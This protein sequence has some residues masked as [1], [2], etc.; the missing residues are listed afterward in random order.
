LATFED[1]KFV[2][3]SFG[4]RIVLTNFASSAASSSCW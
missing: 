1:K 4:T 2:T 3:D